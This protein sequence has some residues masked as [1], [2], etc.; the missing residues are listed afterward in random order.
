[1]RSEDQTTG[2]EPGKPK[3]V[4]RIYWKHL[5]KATVCKVFNLLKNS[6]CRTVEAV[7][8]KSK[9]DPQEKLDNVAGDFA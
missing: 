9:W 1:M 3:R 7:D 8:M 6:S 5:V 2:Q 4:S